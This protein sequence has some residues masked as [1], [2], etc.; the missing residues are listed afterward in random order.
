MSQASTQGTEDYQPL[1]LNHTLTGNLDLQKY[2]QTNSVDLI[3][4]EQITDKQE[5]LT[6]DGNH[7][8]WVSFIYG[9]AIL[10]PWNA[11]L[12]T[13]DFFAYSMPNYPIQFV[14]SFAINGVMVIVVLLSIAYQEYGS[15][16]LK[17]NGVFCA[18]SLLLILLPL[19]VQFTLQSFGELACFWLTCLAMVVLGAITAVSQSAVLSYMS[20]LPDQKYMA[21][22]SVAMGVS[23]L[24]QNGIR[25]LILLEFSSTDLTGTLI[26]YTVTASMLFIAALMYYVERKS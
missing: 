4:Q 22:A 16:A 18:T 10:A 12:S 19:W 23:A 1:K 5:E 3:L 7:I 6:D 25:A 15:H 14:V 11:I 21:I 2:N 24:I 13:L 20:K 8:Y 9:I 26:Y 17:I